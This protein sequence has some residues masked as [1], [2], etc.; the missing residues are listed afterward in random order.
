[1]TREKFEGLFRH[2]RQSEVDKV[3]EKDEVK[4]A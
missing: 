3:I 1:M 4:E 2:P